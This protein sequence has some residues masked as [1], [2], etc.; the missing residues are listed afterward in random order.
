M[1]SR[2]AFMLFVVAPLVVVGGC[3]APG[4]LDADRLAAYRRAMNRRASGAL[5]PGTLLPAVQPSLELLLPDLSRDEVIERLV[6]TTRAYEEDLPPEGKLPRDRIRTTVVVSDF[7]LDPQSDQPDPKTA[8]ISARIEIETVRT[9]R[10][11]PYGGEPDRSPRRVL[12]RMVEKRTELAPD[13]ATGK[14]RRQAEILSTSTYHPVP[15]KTTD[16]EPQDEEPPPVQVKTKTRTRRF[17]AASAGEGTTQPAGVQESEEETTTTIPA[18]RFEGL[19][20]P[21]AEPKTSQRTRIGR[22]HGEAALL[23]QTHK[24][25]RVGLQDAIVGALAANRDIRVVSFEPAISRQEMVKAAAAFDYSL[26][27]TLNF[28][29]QEDDAASGLADGY[30]RFR[31]YSLGVRQQTVSGAAWS[32]RT[33]LSRTWDGSEF[34][35]LYKYTTALE[36]TQPL[37]RGAWPEF[38]LAA[39]R[40]ARLNARLTDAQFR[41]AVEEI[42]TAVTAAY[43]NLVRARRTMEIRQKLLDTTRETHRLVKMRVDIDATVAAVKQAEASVKR[44]RAELIDA[45]LAIG[46]AQDRLVHL[47]PDG[48]LQTDRKQELVPTTAPMEAK[49]RV[50]PAEQL[51]AALRH[52]PQMEQARLA[53]S[54]AEVQVTVAENQALPVLNLTAAVETQGFR[55]SLSWPHHS[56][57]ADE[58]LLG[59][60]QERVAPWPLPV[61]VPIYSDECLLGYRFELLLDYPVGNRLALAELRRARFQQT[62]AVAAMQKTANDLLRAIREQVRR[63]DRTHEKIQAFRGAAEAAEAELQALVESEQ[64]LPRL[65]PA[66]LQTKLQAQRNLA[67]ALENVQQAIFDYNSARA[68]LSRITG[69]VLE[70]NR[71]KIALPAV[72]SAVGSPQP[73][74][75]AAGPPKRP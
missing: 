69:T 27:F 14:L 18:W 75:S 39:L 16:Q 45:R 3:V 61:Q 19:V 50:E 21:P 60:R 26:F 4:E 32:L 33:A 70:L 9:F 30:E 37:L 67:T 29:K 1:D 47:V 62:Q 57:H 17:P 5:R 71:V 25:L 66:F 74:P 48:R 7:D 35:G 24:L 34:S 6:E 40:I 73:A 53:I 22:T 2:A 64:A 63:M 11:E 54:A 52:S 68:E 46:E 38:N 13:P 12:T 36:V 20:G 15:R 59:Y 31:R 28:T 51:V 49:L 23:E 55:R 43:W 42:I 65:E 41:A 10:L 72:I 58:G 8:R 56:L 44:R